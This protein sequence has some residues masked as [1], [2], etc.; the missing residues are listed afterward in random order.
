MT[1]TIEAIL[2]TQSKE[3]ALSIIFVLIY[4]LCITNNLTACFNCLFNV[5]SV[6]LYLSLSV[7]QSI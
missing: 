5:A 1:N 4:F 7:Y 2:Y 6:Y 3:C